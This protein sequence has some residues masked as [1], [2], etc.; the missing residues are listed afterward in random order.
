MDK[1]LD[2]SI[3]RQLWGTDSC[4]MMM[5]VFM[6]VEM[7][8]SGKHQLADDVELS[9]D[10]DVLTHGL[11][12]IVAFSTR[13]ARTTDSLK[14]YPTSVLISFDIIFLGSKNDVSDCIFKMKY[15]S[16]HLHSCFGTR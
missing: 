8:R 11:V 16:R 15:R 12:C 1:R 4:G 13:S 9:Q 6:L 2:C 7:R 10:E 3:S 5:A 14:Y